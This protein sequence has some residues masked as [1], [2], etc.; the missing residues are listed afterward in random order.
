ME[1]STC[2]LW[3][4][5]SPNSVLTE[6]LVPRYGG[7]FGDRA[8][9][10]PGEPSQEI[11]TFVVVY[12]NSPLVRPLCEAIFLGGWAVSRIDLYVFVW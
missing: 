1:T 7:R 8:A 5:G 9:H 2:T 11:A 10:H 6:V 3:R 4:M 12:N